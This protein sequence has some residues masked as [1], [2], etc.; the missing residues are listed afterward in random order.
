MGEGGA[1]RM[2]GG[3]AFLHPYEG[4]IGI[5]PDGQRSR[6]R[7]SS[8]LEVSELIQHVRCRLGRPALRVDRI[9][10]RENGDVN[11]DSFR[12]LAEYSLLEWTQLQTRTCG[13]QD[14]DVQSVSNL[15]ARRI[16][17]QVD[18]SFTNNGITGYFVLRI[19]EISENRFRSLIQKKP[20]AVTMPFGVTTTDP[21]II[22]LRD[23]SV[24]ETL[25]REK[26]MKIQRF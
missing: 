9:N 23:V 4:E 15:P 25:Y 6:L 10:R 13:P 22:Y 16:N 2:L 21:S 17:Y 20:S 5:Y 1:E 24:N 3:R 8:E 26:I 14:F 7:F 11:L 12:E 19:L 18:F